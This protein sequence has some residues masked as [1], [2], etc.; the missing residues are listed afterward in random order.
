M[1]VD[2]RV[3]LIPVSNGASDRSVT[4]ALVRALWRLGEC[5]EHALVIVTLMVSSGRNLR[6]QSLEKAFPFLFSL[7]A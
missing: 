1:K 2:A 7:L 6:V 3:S 4:C 5:R